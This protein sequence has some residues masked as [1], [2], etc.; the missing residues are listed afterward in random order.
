MKKI[1]ALP[2]YDLIL[3]DGMNLLV[4][5]FFAKQFLSYRGKPT[6]MQFGTLTAL[7]Y[8][9]RLLASR[10]KIFFLWEG[11]VSVRK[12]KSISYKANRTSLKHD[13]FVE[14][15]SDIKNILSRI[16]VVQCSHVGLEADD[17]AGYFCKH[18]SEKKILLVTTDRDWYQFMRKDRIDIMTRNVIRT[19]DEIESL[20]QFPP[21]HIAIWK[22]L[23]GDVSDNIKGIPRLPEISAIAFARSCSTLEDLRRAVENIRET[24]WGTRILNNWTTI[25]ENDMLVRFHPEWISRKQLVVVKGVLN[26]P[27]LKS[28]LQNRGMSSLVKHMHLER[29]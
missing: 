6:G 16:D 15:I 2:E 17:L 21:E 26:K 11:G 4:R 29:V 24:K 9:Q 14:S 25:V 3:I 18:F 12:S 20:L 22:A 10:G 13:G 28:Y 7:N 8:L 5:E 27:L 23:K 19:Y 1:S